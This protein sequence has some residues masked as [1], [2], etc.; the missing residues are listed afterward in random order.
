MLVNRENP[1]WWEIEATDGEMEVSLGPGYV[2]PGKVRQLR[3]RFALS[4]ARIRLGHFWSTTYT[5]FDLEGDVLPGVQM[6]CR[7]CGNEYEKDLWDHVK[8]KGKRRKRY[9][10]TLTSAWVSYDRRRLL[11]DMTFHAT[12]PRESFEPF[13]RFMEHMEADNELPKVVREFLLKEDA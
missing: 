13:Y 3:G 1:K 12:V 5:E 10:G 4:N 7:S 9:D 8:E 6:K 2:T 11:K